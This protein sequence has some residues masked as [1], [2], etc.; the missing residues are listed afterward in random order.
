MGSKEASQLRNLDAVG[1]ALRRLKAE[2]IDIPDCSLLEN[3]D[4]LK[5]LQSLVVLTLSSA[6]LCKIWTPSTDSPRLSTSRYRI[7]AQCEI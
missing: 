6:P 5:N 3:V 7:A 2:V 1:P 4:A